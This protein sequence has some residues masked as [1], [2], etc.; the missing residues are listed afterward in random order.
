MIG[1]GFAITDAITQTRSVVVKGARET[2][3]R[4]WV[5]EV[6]GYRGVYDRYLG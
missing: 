1:P 2:A 6:L 3:G 4:G 5:L